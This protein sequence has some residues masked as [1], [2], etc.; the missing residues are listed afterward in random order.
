MHELKENASSFNMFAGWFCVNL[1]N[2][3]FLNDSL[4]SSIEIIDQIENARNLGEETQARIIIHYN[5]FADS[6]V[7]IKQ[8]MQ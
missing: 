7:G 5:K 4:V 8:A 1:W 3:P 2:I 6:K